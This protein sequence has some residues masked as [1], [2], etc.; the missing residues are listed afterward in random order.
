MSHVRGLGLPGCL[1]LAALVSL[2]HSQHGK[3]HLEA[4][5]RDR[6]C[7]KGPEGWGFLPKDREHRD[8]PQEGAMRVVQGGGHRFCLPE[9]GVGLGPPLKGR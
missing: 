3:G 7:G 9:W 4:S 2:V 6:E 1:A 8:S 5:G